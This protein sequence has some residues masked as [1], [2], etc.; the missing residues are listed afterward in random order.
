MAVIGLLPTLAMASHFRGG[1]ITWQG[2]ELDGDGL[3]N[4]VEVTVKTAWRLNGE[5]LPMPTSSPA[6]SFTQ[7]GSNDIVNLNTGAADGQYTLVTQVFR[8]KDLNLQTAYKVRYSSCCRISNLQNNSGGN[9][10]IQTIINL[11]NGNLPPKIDLPIIFEVPQLQQDDSPLANF[12]FDTGSTD[13]NADKL[14]FRLANLE[15]LG[16]SS[17]VQPQGFSINPNTGEVTWSGSGSLPAGLYS[18]GVVAE[19]VD[20]NGVNKSK[21]HVDF[22]LYLQPK[23]AV[24]FSTS[25]N[26]PET[27]NVIVEKGSTYTF[28]VN[29]TAIETTSLGNVRGALT[30]TGTEGEFIFDPLNLDPAAY[31]VTF[32]IR[33]TSG[34]T[35]KSYLILN[36]IVPDPDAPRIVN[37]EA[38]RTVYSAIV[39]QIVDLNVDAVVTDANNIDFDGGVLKFNVSFTDGESEILSVASAGTGS[40]QIS[41]TGNE[42]FYEGVKIG[43]IDANEDG[44]GRALRIALVGANSTPAALTEL[45]R[46]LTYEDTFSLRTSGD[47]NLSLFLQDKD[48]KSNSYNFYVDVQDHPSRPVNGGPVGASNSLIIPEGGTATLG[49]EDLNFADPDTPRSGITLTVSNVVN[50]QFEST[51]QPGVAVTSFTQEAVDLGQ[52][53]FVHNGAETAPSYDVSASDGTDATTPAPASIQFSNTPDAPVISGTPATTAS[54]TYSFVPTVTDGDA[55]EV[56]TFSIANKPAWTTFN[57]ATG[58][59]S[60]NAAAAVPGTFPGIVITVTDSSGLSSSLPTFSITVTPPVDTD[61]DGVPDDVEV[62]QGTD[63]GLEDEFKDTDGDGIPDYVETVVD[64]TDPNDDEKFKDSDGDGVPDYVEIN[65][66][67]TDPLDAGSFLDTDGNGVSDYEQVFRTDRQPPAIV[68]PP[69]VTINATGLRTKV[70]RDQL[71]ALG[72]AT[73]SDGRDGSSCCSPY[74]RSIVDNEPF[75]PPGRHKIVWAAQDAAGNVGVS[76]QILNVLPLVSLSKSQTVPEGAKAEIKVILNGPAPS[77]PVT[78]PYSVSGTAAVPQDHDLVSGVAVIASGLQTTIPV[79]IRLDAAIEADETVVVTLAGENNRGP[80]NQTVLTISERNIQ[81]AASVRV[82]QGGSNRL[83]LTRDGGPVVISGDVKDANPQDVH[84]FE[85]DT[86]ELTVL[87]Q[88]ARTVTLDPGSMA[89]DTVYPVLLGVADSGQPALIDTVLVNLRAVDTL[90]AL[91]AGQ[92]S[93]GDGISDIDEGYSDSDQDGIPDYLD[94]AALDCSAIPEDTADSQRYLMESDP[95]SCIKLGV[96]SLLAQS[97]GSLIDRALEIGDGGKLRLPADPAAENVG[98]IF[99]FTIDDIAEPGQSVR[100]VIPQRAAIPANAFYRKYLPSSGWQDFVEDSRNDIASAPGEAGFCPPA[101]SDLYQSGLLEGFWCVQLTLQD[102]GPND[103]DGD[104]NGVI[105]D[106]GGVSVLPGLTSTGRLKTSGG[107]GSL[108]GETVA[109]LFLGGLAAVLRRRRAATQSRPLFKGAAAPVAV[110]LAVSCSG[111]SAETAETVAYEPGKVFLSAAL[112]YAVTPISESDLRAR[113]NDKGYNANVDSTEDARFAYDFGGGYHLTDNI[114]LEL[115]YLDLGDVEVEFDS[116]QI[117]RRIARV[118]PESGHGVVTSVAYRHALTERLGVGARLGIFF[119]EGDFDTDQGSVDVSNVDDD[120]R[121]LFYGF[122]GD[123][124]IDERWTVKAEFQRFE[125]SRDPSYLLSAGIEFRL[126]SPR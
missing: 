28:E 76:E 81:P 40:G 36:F 46:S 91:A 121:D 25:S 48:G 124:R 113:Y 56:L 85:W 100:V 87:E 9:W 37:L 125:F 57:T 67:S 93:D 75:F 86:G 16:G 21:S 123:Y 6:L 10:D 95:G 7:V 79:N 27:R 122:R 58:E 51:N 72:L 22:I 118:H 83:L 108:G 61:G 19:D 52:I 43:Q 94:S 54:S 114:A 105:A 102:G 4:D 78:V 24:T 107:S 2:L 73:A 66:D 119:W 41:R 39:D 69:E 68:A 33:D 116:A 98:G 55:G 49:T 120:G 77:Y 126:P 29:G 82:M 13:P 110:A 89:L 64:Q 101:G 34:A 12:T 45:V 42:I 47:R 53:R 17:S 32:E 80:A 8:A 59:L 30:E 92:D 11:A 5:N 20:S 60:G 62:S 23:K 96:Y 1:S 31:P 44:V 71:E 50:G 106:P 65:K 112:G 74:P 115:G 88:N 97:G 70:T 103:A 15:E 90:P 99:D 109:M 26:I 63:P 84:V 117:D 14:K 38:D 104:V 111:A 3:Q 35:T 18:A